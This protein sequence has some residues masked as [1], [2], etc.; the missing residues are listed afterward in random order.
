MVEVSVSIG[1]CLKQWSGGG[2]ASKL[3]KLLLSMSLYRFFGSKIRPNPP[4]NPPRFRHTD[5]CCG[6]YK[7]TVSAVK[8]G[9]H[10]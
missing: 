3:R 2:S 6:V 10:R 5:Y 7:T 9:T 8:R 1:S 4:D